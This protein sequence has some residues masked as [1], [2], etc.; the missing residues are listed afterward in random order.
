VPPVGDSKQTSDHRLKPKRD[1][2]EKKDVYRAM[3]S[4]GY[5]AVEKFLIV[6]K[7]TTDKD[8]V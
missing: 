6:A 8:Q 5:H 3:L 7:R 1:K 2:V 4:K